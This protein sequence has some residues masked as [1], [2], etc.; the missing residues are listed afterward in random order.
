MQA[1]PA[2]GDSGDV[3]TFKVGG[4]ALSLPAGDVAE[5]IRLRALT[6]VPHGPAALL[7]VSN[8]RGAVLPVV[9]LAGLMG[10]PV[11]TPAPSS[12]IVVTGNGSAIGL[13]V[14]EVSALTKP[15]GERALDLTALLARDFGALRNF[16]CKGRWP[17]FREGCPHIPRTSGLYHPE[18]LS[19]YSP[20]KLP[21]PLLRLLWIKPETPAPWRPT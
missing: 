7:G 6:R 20:L 11:A 13:L 9:S 19:R 15:Q 10:R 14:D 4:E 5:I 21:L 12:R 1:A 16:A 2:T 17:K 3:L 18:I 8:L